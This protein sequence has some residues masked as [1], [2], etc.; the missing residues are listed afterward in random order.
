[1]TV[2]AYSCECQGHANSWALSAAYTSDVLQPKPR[3]RVEEEEEGYGI[4]FL[5]FSSALT[6]AAS[7]IPYSVYLP[8]FSFQMQDCLLG[9]ISIYAAI[10][11]YMLN[12]QG[13]LLLEEHLPLV[14][15]HLFSG[16]ADEYWCK[17]D[18]QEA[19]SDREERH[20][21]F[22]SLGLFYLQKIFLSVCFFYK[23][24][25][26]I[27]ACLLLNALSLSYYLLVF[28]T[29]SLLCFL[30]FSPCAFASSSSI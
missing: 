7:H 3:R 14:S 22:K 23:N 11:I 21:S 1:M 12:Q 17:M 15:S 18:C 19:S 27:T 8:P 30:S 6:S 24:S 16:K 9:V 29:A 2:E 13:A 26:T 20:H 25:T 4:K 28:F 10:C 5:L